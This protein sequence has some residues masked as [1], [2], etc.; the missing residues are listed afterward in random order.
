[1]DWKPL[2]LQQKCVILSSPIFHESER[3]TS[4]LS[5]DSWLAKDGKIANS[6]IDANAMKSEKYEEN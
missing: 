4:Y 6:S 5:C 3:L 2:L 1:M